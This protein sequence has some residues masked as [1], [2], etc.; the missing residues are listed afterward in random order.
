MKKLCKEFLGFFIASFLLLGLISPANANY[1]KLIGTT[2][3]GYTVLDQ[4]VTG[5]VWNNTYMGYSGS[6]YS[7]YYLGTIEAKN[8]DE[9]LF[10]KL[11]SAYLGYSVVEEAFWKA[12]KENSWTEGSLAVTLDPNGQTGTWV[13]SESYEIGFYGVKAA[14]NF[15][16]YFVYPYESS[17][18]WS[19]EHLINPGGEQPAISHLQV[20]A[21]KAVPEPF[22]ML[23]LGLGL[24]GLAGVGRKLKK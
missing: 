16:L 20:S 12:E 2:V 4:S 5:N 10:E 9:T 3:D 18:T 13:L 7:G 24:V 6:N 21:N 15:A 1:I 17:G 11:A 19:T 14:N 22:S 8:V 23:L